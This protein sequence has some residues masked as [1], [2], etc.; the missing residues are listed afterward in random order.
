MGEGK[1][2]VNFKSISQNRI[3]FSHKKIFSVKIFNTHIIIFLTSESLLDSLF[4]KIFEI[5][6]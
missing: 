5:A 2:H 6:F 1:F 3:P 4:P